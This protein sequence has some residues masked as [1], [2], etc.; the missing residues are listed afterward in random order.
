MAAQSDEIYLNIANINVEVGLA[1]SQGSY[2][3]TFDGGATID[4]VIDAPSAD[5]EEFHNQQTHIWH[6]TTEPGGGLEL[7][8]DLGVSYDITA[9]HFWNY[10]SEDYDVDAVLFTFFDAAGEKLGTHALVPDLGTRPGIKAQT[11]P[12]KSPMNTRVV[13]A[14]LTGSNGEIDFQNIGFTARLSDPQYDPKN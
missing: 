14:F 11:I 8:F 9:L 1:T 4:K 5:A 2:N 12:L 6:T 13:T 3:N 7:V 10:T